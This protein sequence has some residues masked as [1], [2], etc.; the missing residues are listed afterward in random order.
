MKSICSMVLFRRFMVCILFV[1]VLVA[2]ISFTGTA[3]AVYAETFT[4]TSTS[5][6]ILVEGSLRYAIKTATSEDVITFELEYPAIITL[7]EQLSIDHGLTIQGPGAD[8]LAVSGGGKCR[9]FY[10]EDTTESVDIS[11]ISI[12]SG[13]AEQ[14]EHSSGGGIYNLSDYLT[15]DN[16]RFSGNY[17]EIGG[18]MYNFSSSPEVINCV[19]NGNIAEDIGS[20]YGGGIFNSQSSPKVSSCTFY[21][22]YAISSNF[23]D[24][25]GGGIANS[26]G[27]NPVVTN[28]TFSGNM[29]KCGGGLY[30]LSSNPI[31]TNCTFSLNSADYGGGMYSFNACSPTV[32]NCIFWDSNG[33]EI[34][35]DPD[36]FSP[37]IPQLSFCVVQSNDVGNGTISNDIIS[38]DPNLQDLADNGGPT[39]T[40][41]L[42]EGSSAID[43]GMTIA[44]VST[45]QRGAPRPEDVS[46]DIGAYEDGLEV[47]EITA[48]C[49]EGGAI[50]PTEA[51]TLAGIEDEVFYLIP[52]EGY[53]IEAVYVDEGVVSYDKASNTYTFH[54]VSADHEISADFQPSASDYDM[55]TGNSDGC[56][57]SALPGMTLLVVLPL[58]FLS[59]KMK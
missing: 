7:N 16:C 24:S 3:T 30:N 50:S 40:C 59:G 41:A 47:Y 54:N 27:S 45:D 25:Y 11:G 38:A 46:F 2:F 31:V 43:A 21:N 13:D 15:V 55:I 26:D 23:G 44:E 58:L 56:N 5:D 48:T 39:C 57:V 35:I 4:V 49:S 52:D 20:T 12:V 28:C 29:A 17:A 18:G 51:H 37:S 10:I 6:D 9:V 14:Y 19:L 32:T 36:E 42:G 53:V 8:L 1:F 22:N 34:Y 33:G